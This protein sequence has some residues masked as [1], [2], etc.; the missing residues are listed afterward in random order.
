MIILGISVH[1]FSLYFLAWLV[2]NVVV[3]LKELLH[4]I[5]FL[6][7]LLLD[8]WYGSYWL[9]F[10][11]I[12]LHFGLYLDMFLLC[13][14]CL[15]C[16]LWQIEST[17]YYRI[18]FMPRHMNALVFF[19]LEGIIWIRYVRLTYWVLY[20]RWTCHARFWMRERSEESSFRMLSLPLPLLS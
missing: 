8:N 18:D 4:L 6:K 15:R 10:S 12:S 11:P 13:S 20:L 16:L 3:S 14:V 1:I 5:C 19:C 2:M 17:Y 7:E 9:L